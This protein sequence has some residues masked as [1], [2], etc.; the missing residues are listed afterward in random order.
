MPRPTYVTAIVLL[1]ALTA[2]VVIEATLDDA[3]GPWL[4]ITLPSDR[5]Y[6]SE[7]SLR[8]SL[9]LRSS[10]RPLGECPEGPSWTS[11]LVSLRSVSEAIR[12]SALRG[13]GQCCCAG[14]LLIQRL[15]GSRYDRST[16]CLFNRGRALRACQKWAAGSW[17]SIAMVTDAAYSVM[18]E[19]SEWSGDALLPIVAMHVEGTSFGSGGLMRRMGL[20][21]VENEGKVARQ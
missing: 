12:R 1:N 16:L 18:R 19:G 8:P 9:N 4:P 5:F 3:V 14:A 11:L 15:E 20:G 6:A 7:T 21:P 17:R 13:S 10:R 2:I